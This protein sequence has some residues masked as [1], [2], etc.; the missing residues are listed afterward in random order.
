METDPLPILTAITRDIEFYPLTTAVILSLAFILILLFSSALISGSEVAYFSLNPQDREK[1]KSTKSKQNHAILKNLENPEKLLATILVAN[2]FVNVGIV[3]LSAY[4][5]GKLFNFEAAPTIGFIFQV[6]VI[7]FVL[8]LFGEIVPKVYASSHPLSFARFMAIPLTVLERF[9]SPINAILIHSTSFVNKHFQKQTQNISVNELSQALELT[10]EHEHAEDKEILE[11]IVKFGNKNVVEIMRSRVDVEALEIKDSY[12]KVINKIN[13]SGYS[14]V[15]VY[16]G[17]FDNIK[18][19][20]Y[21]KDL[22]PHIHKKE[23]F[24]WQT[25][26]RPPFYVPETKKIDDL[27]EEFQKNKV[28]MAIV[29]DE[30]GGSSGIVTLEDVLEEIVGEIADEF[31]DDDNYFT[32]IAENKYL[33]DGKILLNDFYKVTGSNDHVFDDYK[34]DADTLAGLILELKGEIPDKHEKL[35]C[36]NFVFTIEAVDNRR[37]KKIKVEIN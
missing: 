26:I 33:F 11:G 16:D 7:T 24:K 2:N 34:G 32:K 5:T 6:V 37:I 27:L 19:I 14:R 29:V 1:L 3:I 10:L 13:E 21:I 12:T 17:S 18:G 28:H 25:I 15:P 20:L 4:A 31:D 30:Y 23:N 22:L 8:L 9:F 36:E 35:N